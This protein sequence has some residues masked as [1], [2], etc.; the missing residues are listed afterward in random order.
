MANLV[1]N[2]SWKGIS[3]N[4]INPLLKQQAFNSFFENYQNI[5]RL[6]TVKEVQEVSSLRLTRQY[7]QCIRNLWWATRNYVLA[8][9]KSFESQ[10]LLKVFQ[11][12]FRQST[13]FLSHRF[14]QD[15]FCEYRFEI[16]NRVHPLANSPLSLVCTQTADLTTI[17]DV[18]VLDFCSKL[19][20][21]FPRLFFFHYEP[22]I[23][24]LVPDRRSYQFLE[25]IWIYL[26]DCIRQQLETNKL[27]EQF[28]SHQNS[29]LWKN[30][31]RD[32]SSLLADA[33]VAAPIL[34][35]VAVKIALASG[36]KA[37]FGPNKMHLIKTANSIREKV[38]RNQRDFSLSVE[39]SVQKIDDV[40]RGTVA[41]ERPQQVFL[42]TQAFLRV[43]PQENISSIIN[44][45]WYREGLE[46]DGGYVDIDANL[47]ITLKDRENRTVLGELQ[48][49]FT[50]FFDGTKDCFVARAHKIYELFRMIGTKSAHSI[51]IS[52]PELTYSS[53]LYFTTALFQIAAK[54]NSLLKPIREKLY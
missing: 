36:G 16:L 29:I 2:Q 31:A 22:K 43:A 50:E 54:N 34:E 45:L 44:D 7:S 27:H 3:Q 26:R 47:S 51:N 13:F 15:H 35:R 18:K 17:A 21:C 23:M 25:K 41:V 8:N 42:A 9:P 4:L 5:L 20:R 39:A 38:E 32:I 30:S 37:L 53:L 49:H 28:S 46:E 52:Q 40:V 19:E 24:G 48:V 10:I 6:I 33:D 1:Q 11:A 14:D 12:F